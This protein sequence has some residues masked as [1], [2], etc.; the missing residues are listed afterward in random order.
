M[1]RVKDKS[2]MDRLGP[3]CTLPPLLAA[4]RWA[5]PRWAEISHFTWGRDLAEP[6]AGH[7]AMEGSSDG[8][9]APAGDAKSRQRDTPAW[10][11]GAAG[12]RNAV[13]TPRAFSVPLNVRCPPTPGHKSFESSAKGL[14]AG[15]RW[16]WVALSGKS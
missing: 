5:D 8:S 14:R 3:T 6:P 11:G 9:Q 12:R 10:P 16:L 13:L 4:Q 1:V 7:R 15:F 2:V